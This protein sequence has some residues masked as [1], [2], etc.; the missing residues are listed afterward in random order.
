MTYPM[1]IVIAAALFA[2]P[3]SASGQGAAS[4]DAE[5]VALA[6]LDGSTVWVGSRRRRRQGLPPRHARHGA[7]R[8]PLLRLG[9]LSGQARQAGQPAPPRPRRQEA[10]QPGQGMVDQLGH[11]WL[12]QGDEI[13]RPAENR[14][15]G[16]AVQPVRFPARPDQPLGRERRRPP[17]TRICLMAMSPVWAL[18]GVV[19]RSEKSPA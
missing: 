7:A 11:R 1:A 2:A 8:R 5:G 18:I 15:I 17:A 12:A 14:G 16:D 6:V 9:T 4:P 19:G 3:Y 13:D 10:P